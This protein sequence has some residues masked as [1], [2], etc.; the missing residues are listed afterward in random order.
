MVR[1]KNMVKELYDLLLFTII[2]LILGCL[3]AGITIILSGV[4]QKLFGTIGFIIF[5]IFGLTIGSYIFKNIISW[6]GD[7]TEILYS[8]LDRR[9]K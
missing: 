4:G 6:L 9:K 5:G 8:F 1:I 2:I 3:S 7:N